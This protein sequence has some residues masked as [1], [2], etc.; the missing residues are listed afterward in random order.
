MDFIFQRCVKCAQ[1]RVLVR[2]SSPINHIY[3]DGSFAIVCQSPHTHTCTWMYE[4]ALGFTAQSIKCA[5]IW[6]P[7]DIDI[8]NY[9]GVITV[10]QT[11]YRHHFAIAKRRIHK[12]VQSINYDIKIG[13]QWLLI[14]C[15]LTSFGKGPEEPYSYTCFKLQKIKRMPKATEHSNWN[16]YTSSEPFLMVG[17]LNCCHIEQMRLMNAISVICSSYQCRLRTRIPNRPPVPIRLSRFF[18]CS[19][20]EMSHQREYHSNLVSLVCSS[21]IFSEHIAR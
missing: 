6:T 10:T 19:T 8:Y 3:V 2:T 4:S 15:S 20:H 17:H 1:I 16:R 5:H 13:H 12:T 14:K 21:Q 11:H 9:P 7:L 18:V